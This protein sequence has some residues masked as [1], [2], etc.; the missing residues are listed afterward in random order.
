MSWLSDLVHHSATTHLVAGISLLSFGCSDDNGTAFHV[1]QYGNDDQAGTSARPFGTLDRARQA[2]HDL[3]SDRRGNPV[4]IVIDG[5][6]ELPRPL[7]LTPADS[8]APDAPVTWR[9]GK[10]GKPAVLRGDRKVANW[11]PYRDGIWVADISA[12]KL[13][14]GKLRQITVNGK[15]RYRAASPHSG[16]F[17]VDYPALTKREDSPKDR[18]NFLPGDL[19]PDWKT[20]PESEIVVFHFWTDS[21]LPISSI[22]PSHCVT[23]KMPSKKAF[24]DDY[25]QVGARY[26]V[27]GLIELLDKP[28]EWA[29]DREKKKIYYMPF[30][31]EDMTTTEVRLPVMD[32]LIVVKGS[33]ETGQSVE[34]IVFEK[35]GFAGTD[36]A[37]PGNSV[38][39]GQA[40]TE[41]TAA[42]R[43]MGAR[44]VAVAACTFEQLGGYAVELGPGAFDCAL[45][46]NRMVDLGAGGI[47]IGGANDQQS[48]LHRNGGHRIEDNEI[49]YYGNVFPSG[50]GI[51]IQR[52]ERN[53]VSHN[54][55]HHGFYSGI[56]VGWS[57]GYGRSLSRSNVVEFNHIHDIGQG[58]LSDMGGI[59]TLGVSPGTTIRNNVISNVFANN[60][61]GW[62]IYM[63]EGSTGILVENNTVYDTEH[64]SLMI[65]YGRDLVVR[66]NIFAFGEKSQLTRS[67]SEPHMSAFFENN[68]VYWKSGVIF[69]G[70]WENKPFEFYRKPIESGKETRQASFTSN[71]NVFF[72]PDI[73]PAKAPFPGGSLTA[74]HER[75]HD[76][77][78]VFEDPQ[79]ADVANRD[80]NLKLTSPAL[81]LGFRPIAGPV[82]PRQ[83][84]PFFVERNTS[85]A[86]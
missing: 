16:F 57:W 61:G 11:Q 17:R 81:H 13:P 43:I 59:Y 52:S 5:T 58:L 6:I 29:L 27:E 41:T 54:H 84:P 47:R 74:W 80:F 66:N 48:P 31:D 77:N 50:V 32:S 8:G 30:A 9:S 71:W 10:E 34:N 75:G 37:L 22:G 36:F 83:S 67:R 18:F 28:G 62:G 64:G 72:N 26:R 20:N 40:S 24:T 21:H 15:T 63:D 1:S 56:S 60:Y 49:G 19:D 68:I 53:L 78:S 12:I 55:V 44:K 7:I 69:E 39:D 42:V 45:L 85:A 3:P 51:L 33:A 46:G 73:S 79:F 38:N 4:A 25:T 82:G 86:R 23:F 76:Q 2:V 70:D 65:H 35:I 14:E